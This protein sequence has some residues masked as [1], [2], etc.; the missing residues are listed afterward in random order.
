MTS[1]YISP[2][3]T[4]TTP[5]TEPVIIA[6]AWTARLVGTLEL[7]DGCL[8]VIS[9]PDET[10]YVLVWPPDYSVTIEKTQVRV[11]SG[12]VTGDHREVQ[13]HIGET[14]KVSGGET[15]ALSEDLLQSLPSDC[16][17]PYWV[18]G[19]NAA[20]HPSDEQPN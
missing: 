14:V 7:T 15:G 2:A 18:V 16:P 3:P 5:T 13:L 20:P 9:S 1:C 8:H 19:F 12:N 4:N 11:I 6:T 17:G 10:D